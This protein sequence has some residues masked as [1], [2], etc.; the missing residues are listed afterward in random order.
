MS[1]E[2][3]ATAYS[4]NNGDRIP[5]DPDTFTD[6]L[7]NATNVSTAAFRFAKTQSRVELEI[8]AVNE[9]TIPDTQT[10]TIE[11]LWDTDEAGTFTSSRE[12][13]SFAPS[14]GAQVI[15]AGTSIGIIT[16]E[17]DVEHYAKVKYTASSDLSA[18][19][20]RRELYRTA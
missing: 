20:V 2:S 6:D 15:T 11:L 12:I 7:P 5:A 8:F 19:D 14:G 4:W 18:F 1:V 3:T 9:I 17:T 16:P 10:L 13:A